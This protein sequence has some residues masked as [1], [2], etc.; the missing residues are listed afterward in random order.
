MGSPFPLLICTY[1]R[2]SR[3]AERETEYISDTGEKV[4]VGFNPKL[5]GVHVVP[6]AGDLNHYSNSE[7]IPF[8]EY[9]IQC[10]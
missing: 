2:D 6:E 8:E 9:C 7:H 3:T 10:S 4:L 5:A 1:Y